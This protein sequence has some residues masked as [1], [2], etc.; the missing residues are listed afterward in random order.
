SRTSLMKVERGRKN[1]HKVRPK[2][3]S[4][5][6]P[7]ALRSSQ[8]QTS[9][10]NLKKHPRKREK[11]K[12]PIRQGTSKKSMMAGRHIRGYIRKSR[13][14]HRISF[15][16]YA[17]MPI[18]SRQSTRSRARA[19]DMLK[20]ISETLDREWTAYL[21][22]LKEFQK[23]AMVKNVHDLRVSIRRLMTSMELIERFNPDSIVR[24]ARTTLKD[25]LSG[26]SD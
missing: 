17:P 20:F 26:L 12:K 3:F 5:S 25:Q 23:Q 15:K 4:K 22:S 9:V 18:V 2:K 7:N 11:G 10:R 24:R 14:S 19:P 21:K 8:R 6:S 16:R 13:P 1:S